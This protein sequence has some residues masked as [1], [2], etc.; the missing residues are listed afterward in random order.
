[1]SELKYSKEQVAGDLK[2]NLPSSDVAASQT[3]NLQ[4][5]N[6]TSREE[7][8]GS[9]EEHLVKK[10]KRDLEIWERKSKRQQPYYNY[11][12]RSILNLEIQEIASG[13]SQDDVYTFQES[14][15]G[16][17][18]W[19]VMEKAIFFAA[20][21][22][23]GKDN[24]RGIS[25]RI[26]SKSELEV[27]EYLLVL[28]EKT[29]SMISHFSKLCTLLDIP[30]ASEISEDCCAL[31]EKAADALA[32]REEY[33]EAKIEQEKWDALWIITQNYCDEFRR[34]R[35]RFKHLKSMEEIQPFLDLFFLRN[36]FHLTEHIFMNSSTNEEE[37]WRNFA[38]PGERP[39]IRTT[40]LEDFY[41][42]VINLTKKLVSATIFCTMSRLRARGTDN[43]K[44]IEANLED[45]EA[46]IRT[47]G[48]KRNNEKYWTQCARRCQLSIVDDS[49]NH[50]T[51]DE[52]ESVMAS[53]APPLSFEN[54]YDNIVLPSHDP[55]FS[56]TTSIED[57]DPHSNNH[58][59]D[60]DLVISSHETSDSLN[61]ISYNR[62]KDKEI[63]DESIEIQEQAA[64]ETEDLQVDA[65]DM[66]SSRAEEK[67]LM[68]MLKLE[69]QF[70]IN[71]EELSAAGQNITKF[72]LNPRHIDDDWREKLDYYSEWETLDA[73]IRNESFAS[74]RA[75]D[76][77][78]TDNKLPSN[79]DGEIKEDLNQVKIN[80]NEYYNGLDPEISKSNDSESTSESGDDDI[81]SSARSISFDETIA[82]L[83]GLAANFQPYSGDEYED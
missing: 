9:P 23:L 58:D 82:Q 50:M 60:S 53:H 41:S 30:A 5:S 73:Q 35:N 54:N 7:Q 43:S 45:A 16:S 38:D 19:K 51:Y 34:R 24:I 6:A 25:A 71:N 27:K 57:R 81:A 69:P 78:T 28:E 80:S 15:I 21:D 61:T 49:K 10:R 76:L 62:G 47:L 20:L 59:L 66:Q 12:Y 22:S 55:A 36:W 44:L 37:N 18:I 77:D 63:K 46:A 31:L 79:L 8:H 64:E 3:G 32:A 74:S 67:N 68:E 13:V 1:M 14:Q 42:L 2:L 29:R 56:S 11:E 40:A 70:E 83:R 48:L 17:S 75:E 26:G 72:T 33:E 65:I 39:A 4:T 52:V